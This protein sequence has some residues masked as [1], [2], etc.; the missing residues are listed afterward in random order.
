MNEGV[1]D[2]LIA[3]VVAQQAVTGEAALEAFELVSQPRG[4]VGVVVKVYLDL[5][6]P[7]AAEPGQ[8]LQVTRVILLFGVEER[9]LRR[10]SIRI[11]ELFG[12]SRE[13]LG[14]RRNPRVL[15][16][17]CR[18][19]TRG[20]EVVRDAKENVDARRGGGFS[21][22]LPARRNEA[23]EPKLGIPRKHRGRSY[24]QPSGAGL[25]EIERL[26]GARRGVDREASLCPPTGCIAKSGATRG[27][28]G[29]R[30]ERTG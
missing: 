27:V 30:H 10:P 15:C 16:R 29:Q 22:P 21:R 12:Q 2:L 6:E 25:F 19:L 1:F 14:P 9:V 24:V 23:G 5:S 4:C 8:R 20:L 7:G 28:A 26:V 11:A 3:A 17:E 13:V 18:L